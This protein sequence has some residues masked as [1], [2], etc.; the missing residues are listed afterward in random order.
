MFY[1]AAAGKAPAEKNA[2]NLYFVRSRQNTRWKEL[3]YYFIEPQQA[4]HPL[5][6]THIFFILSAAGKT[7]AEKNLTIILLSRSRQSTRWKKRI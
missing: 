4:K 2:Y 6:K 7:P 3:N 1:W 5:K